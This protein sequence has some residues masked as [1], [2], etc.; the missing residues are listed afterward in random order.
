[1]SKQSAADTWRLHIF[2][3]GARGET[4][5]FPRLGIFESEVVNVL[6]EDDIK[7]E[8]ELHAIHK[9]REAE[10]IIVPNCIASQTGVT[11]FYH[12][13]LGFNSSLRQPS[14]ENESLYFPY[15][16]YDHIF[17]EG[18]QTISSQRIDTVTLD[19]FILNNNKINC[20][21]DILSIDAEG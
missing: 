11:D 1:M 10:V 14:R 17:Y 15:T 19:D 5:S 2:H 4:Q 20:P 13:R 8:G 9:G 18:A 6:F 12:A 21:P 7:A 16:D 3:I